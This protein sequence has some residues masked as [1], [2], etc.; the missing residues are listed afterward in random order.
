MTAQLRLIDSSDTDSDPDRYIDIG[1]FVPRFAVVD[2]NETPRATH[3]TAERALREA[4]SWARALGGVYRVVDTQDGSIL[5]VVACT[6]SPTWAM[7]AEET[8]QGELMSRDEWLARYRTIER[9]AEFPAPTPTPC[10]WI[11][12]RDPHCR[13]YRCAG[14]LS[15]VHCPHARNPCPPGTCWLCDRAEEAPRSS[16]SSRSKKERRR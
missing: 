15:N 3:T 1:H 5:A 11:N 9:R 6:Q 12:A 16:R 2:G 10:D 8:E 13:C 7:W 4:D 14:Q